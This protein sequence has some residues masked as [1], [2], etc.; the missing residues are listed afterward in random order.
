MTIE[1]AALVAVAVLLCWATLIGRQAWLL[2]AVLAYTVAVGW[3]IQRHMALLLPALGIA[4]ALAILGLA[5]AL[6]RDE[7]I[8]DDTSCHNECD[9]STSSAAQGE[10][11]G[12]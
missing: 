1:L 3:I 7:E 11:I 9:V 10:T 2:I 12:P 8:Q 6:R 5:L 4:I